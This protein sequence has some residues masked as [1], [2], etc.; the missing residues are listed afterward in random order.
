MTERFEPTSTAYPDAV[1]SPAAESGTP[2][3]RLAA[4]LQSAV[5]DQV[6]EQRQLSQL[7]TEVRAALSDRGDGQATLRAVERLESGLRGGLERTDLQISGLAT[8]LADAQT[9]LLA[10]REQLDEAI[11]EAGEDETTLLQD[12]HDGLAGLRTDLRVVPETV[13]PAIAQAVGAG[14]T[15][16]GRSLE[17]LEVAQES[18]SHDLVALQ[19]ELAEL[20]PQLEAYGPRLDALPQVAAALTA[21]A[22]RS[23]ALED[24]PAAVSALR[25]QVESVRASQLAVAASPPAPTALGGAEIANIVR[26]G[27]RDA[28]RDF[29]RDYLRQAVQDIVTV[30]TRDTE[31]RIT[32]HVDEAV[33]ALAQALLRRRPAVEAVTVPSSESF[34]VSSTVAADPGVEDHPGESADQPDE[35]VPLVDARDPLGLG[36][37][38]PEIDEVIEEV[39]A[40]G[41]AP[42]S[43]QPAAAQGESH[44]AS[45]R[46]VDPLPGPPAAE[47]DAEPPAAVSPAPHTHLAARSTVRPTPT[48]RPRRRGL[49]RR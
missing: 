14:L 32:D 4:L 24:V 13:A 26:E 28:T 48:G 3:D 30:S 37:R 2:G 29:V 31:R 1:T 9:A 27:V 39:A 47:P 16:V 20:W 6:A 42:V 33:L 25:A 34:P 11:V 38:D 21:L 46:P 5:D 17:R 49:F 40:P 45:A 19:T 8:R 44:E 18:T 22:D 41:P 7:L 35:R 36:A 23:K 43:A 12:V 10:V 15:D